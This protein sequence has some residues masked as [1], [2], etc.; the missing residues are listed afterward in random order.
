MPADTPAGQQLLQ[1]SEEF[2]DDFQA[3]IHALQAA[4]TPAVG[5]GSG[6]SA[7][8]KHADSDTEQQQWQQQVLQ[9]IQQQP[10]EAFRMF[11]WAQ[12]LVQ[13]GAVEVQHE[14]RQ[15]LVLVPGLEG[16]P[17]VSLF[18]T[19]SRGQLR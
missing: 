1:A 9:C 16:V 3:L 14:G 5:A 18:C 15:A 10:Q 13:Q 2:Q 19:F 17:K 4:T 12:Q 11:C 7:D 6:S 8:D